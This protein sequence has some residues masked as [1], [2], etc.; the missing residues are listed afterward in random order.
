M[1]LAEKNPRQRTLNLSLDYTS[2]L[3]ANGLT[4]L[5][6]SHA[7]LD[8]NH[9]IDAL[10]PR[11]LQQCMKRDLDIRFVSLKEDWH[12]FLK[13]VTSRA[14]Q[15]DAFDDGTVTGPSVK[16]SP[17]AGISHQQVITALRNSTRVRMPRGSSPTTKTRISRSA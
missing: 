1:K 16:N 14:E 17:A 12:G 7:M 8:V 13:H 3:R 6:E 2:L 9:I 15:L 4:W 5:L 11:A 10:R